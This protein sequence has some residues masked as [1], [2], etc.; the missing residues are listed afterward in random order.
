MTETK[1]IRETKGAE[2]W[3]RVSMPFWMLRDLFGGLGLSRRPR[4]LP[5]RKKIVF[6]EMP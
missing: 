1:E 4:K 6:L 5:R 3:K 2:R